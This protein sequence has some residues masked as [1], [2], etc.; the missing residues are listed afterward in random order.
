M[1]AKIKITNLSDAQWELLNLK[2]VVR[3]T[4]PVIDWKTEVEVTFEAAHQVERRLL[5]S[6]EATDA[7]IRD[8]Q[9]A[10]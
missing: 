3:S 5:L 9:D 7:L 1:R 6:W 2:Q 4:A 10:S 8:L